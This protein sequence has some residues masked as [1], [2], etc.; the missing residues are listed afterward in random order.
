MREFLFV[1]QER[2]RAIFLAA[3]GLSFLDAKDG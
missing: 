2:K 3:V 1:N